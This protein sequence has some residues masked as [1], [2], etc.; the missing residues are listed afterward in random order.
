MNRLGFRVTLGVLMVAVSGAVSAVGLGELRGQPVLGDR[1][2]L[3]VSIL[4]V[5]R[6]PPDASCFRLVKPQGGDDLPWLRQADFLVGGGKPPVLTI[7]SAQVL[8]EP[9]IQVAVH[10]A[11]GYEV[12]R[13]YTLLASPYQE[14]PADP[15]VVPR[16][17]TESPVRRDV[18]A[19]EVAPRRK[20]ASVPARQQPKSPTPELLPAVPAMPTE[21]VSDRLLLSAGDGDGDSS[22]RLSTVLGEHMLAS[23]LAEAQREILRLEFRMLSA[24]HEQAT[25]QLEAAEKLRNMESTLGELQGK[26]Q[27][28]TESANALA[29]APS[30]EAAPRK[31]SAGE[32]LKPPVEDPWLS[33]WMLYGLL[34]GL[35]LGLG[36]WLFW[37][38]RR[39]HH[40][41]EGD[42]AGFV[43]VSP[44]PIVDAPRQ[45]EIEEKGGVDLH[46]E[47][48]A[49]GAPLQVDLELEN[50]VAPEVAAPAARATVAARPGDSVLSINATTLDEHFEANPVMELADIMLSFGRV[51]G[52]A[53]AL[54]E[55]IDNNPQ[56]ALQPWIRLMDVYR[57][58]GMREEFDAVAR[59]LNQQFNVEVQSWDVA[60]SAP[61]DLVLDDGTA[62]ENL[63][64]PPRAQGLEDMPRI[65][66]GVVRM[67]DSEDVVGYLYQL[68]R[69]NR[70]GQRQGFA[71]PVVEEILFLI[72]LK[73]T[74]NRMEKETVRHG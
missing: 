61:V 67:W 42:L 62:S 24:L 73:E 19:R 11:C 4:G 17:K 39:E 40:L 54:Q 18:A 68:L 64:Q 23:N 1:L 63:S 26:A 21:P 69:D 30:T 33:D 49:M 32:P 16:V 46:L 45:G 25:S 50:N 2:E 9:V 48:S 29:S 52:A 51:K 59:N 56:E 71:L 8:R 38:N 37:R 6:S 53:Q 58:A 7:R 34:L 41:G 12:Y 20:P 55:Y 72:E 13:E 36:G 27:A 74:A 31:P 57:M 28:M 35:L 14:P 43:A 65:M 5:E 3:T 66:S 47:P 60:G 44:E 70:G 15:V 10:L 22:L